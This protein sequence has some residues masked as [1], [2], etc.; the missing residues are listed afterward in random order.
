MINFS[1]VVAIESNI[2]GG[3]SCF[4]LKTRA[5]VVD[6]ATYDLDM[7]DGRWRVDNTRVLGWL[8]MP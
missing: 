7:N 6:R 1:R 4:E 3:D 5:S 8:R 2:T